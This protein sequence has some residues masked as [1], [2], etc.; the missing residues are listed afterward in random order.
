[1]RFEA[2]QPRVPS[3]AADS[4]LGYSR[5]LPNGRLEFMWRREVALVAHDFRFFV[6]RAVAW[7]VPL[8][9]KQFS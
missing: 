2:N 4:S 6:A 9:L 5:G 3:A 7:A 8:L 1:M